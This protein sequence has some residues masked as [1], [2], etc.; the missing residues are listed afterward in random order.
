[1]K[2]SKTDAIQKA[3]RNLFTAKKTRRSLKNEKETLLE[4]K[5]RIK[6]EN[7]N[8]DFEGEKKKNIAKKRYQVQQEK[9]V[10]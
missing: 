4:Q 2:V 6:L 10:L 1:M 3:E 7:L 5:A 9:K 8:K